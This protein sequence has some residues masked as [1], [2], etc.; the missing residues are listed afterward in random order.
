MESFSDILLRVAKESD[1]SSSNPKKTLDGMREL[2]RRLP[3][4]H[5]DTVAYLMR[6]LHRVSLESDLNNMP[7]SNLG[8]VFGPT[9]LRMSEGSASLN[10]LVDTVHQTKAIE[11]LIENSN[12]IFG[13]ADHAA[14]PHAPASRTEGT[15]RSLRWGSFQIRIHL[16]NNEVSK[17]K[18][19]KNLQPL[20]FFF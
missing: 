11:I 4:T 20:S 9:L 19:N 3:Q 8:I 14:T 1:S 5:Y 18:V 10:S 7:P 2:V 17:N 16:S 12:E 13:S 6:H 15:T